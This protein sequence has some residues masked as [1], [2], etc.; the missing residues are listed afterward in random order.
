MEIFYEMRIELQVV[1]PNAH[2]FFE[3]ARFVIMAKVRS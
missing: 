2:H 1:V 3:G